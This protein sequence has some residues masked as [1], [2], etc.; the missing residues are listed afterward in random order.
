M[1][2]TANVRRSVR[3]IALLAADAHNTQP[4][5][6]KLRRD[7]ITMSIS[8]DDALTAADHEFATAEQTEDKIRRADGRCDDLFDQPEQRLP[9]LS[10]LDL[11]VTKPLWIVGVQHLVAK[12]LQ[13]IIVDVIELHAKL[14]HGNRYQLRRLLVAGRQ[15]R[16]P[17]LLQGS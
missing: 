13:I 8:P 12:G 7:V 14:E 5:A 9:P 15:Q 6:G 17:A 1:Q 11:G 4:V 10:R 2:S 16:S 3:H